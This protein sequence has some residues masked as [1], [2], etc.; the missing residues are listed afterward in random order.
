MNFQNPTSEQNR[1]R[2]L[3]PLILVPTRF[4]LRAI[5]SGVE[6]CGIPADFECIG[7]GPGAVWRWAESRKSMG[8]ANSPPART[9]ILAGLAG[10]LDPTFTVATVRSAEMIIGAGAD[11][12]RPSPSY[13]PPL[14][15]KHTTVIASVDNVCA[16][17]VSKK[18]LRDQS[19]AGMVD[20]ESAAFAS[21]A[22]KRGWN[23]G[24]FRA[25]SDDSV[26]DI[27][28][29]IASLVRVDG[30]L[31]VISLATSVLAHPSRIARLAAIGASARHALRELCLE[32]TA[33][34]SKC[35]R[36]QRTLIF[37]GTFDPPHRRHAQMVAQAA[38]FLGCNR[39]IILP[40]GQSPLRE[41]NAS[42]SIEHR[43]AMATLAF[44]EVPGVVIDPREMNR[45]GESFTVD[46]LREIARES[47]AISQDLVLLI[48]ADQ[49]LQFDRWKE[50]REIDHAL[51][52]IAIVPRPPLSARQ[53][54]AQ[55]DEKFSR[56]GEDGERWEK[57]VLPFESVDLSATEIRSRLR[58][59]QNIGDLVS[60]AVEAWIRQY[61]LYA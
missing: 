45:S 20:M 42:A 57:A 52:T 17:Q 3:P 26:T 1:E 7:V 35:D 44:S 29:W 22:T 8:A 19:G 28:P 14:R 24:V 36:P 12:C 25:V 2:R 39:V 51:A 34:L 56:L 54:A 53:L 23:W 47:G 61:G 59:G 18:I 46:T 15:S 55:L 37:G 48:G 16:D 13:S 21:L 33:I 30:S 9:V 41:G 4:E 60:P 31:D 27:P 6:K 5:K 10:A 49:A 32:L 38:N 58:S 43:L 11:F 50:W 40:A